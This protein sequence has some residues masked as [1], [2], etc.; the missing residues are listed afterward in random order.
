MF[1]YSESRST[2]FSSGHRNTC[3]ILWFKIH[4]HLNHS[5]HNRNIPPLQNC[6]TSYDGAMTAWYQSECRV[7]CQWLHDINQIVNFSVSDCMNTNLFVEF[8]VNVPGLWE[9]IPTKTNRPQVS[10]THKLL[11][12]HS[13]DFRTMTPLFFFIITHLRISKLVLS[14]KKIIQHNTQ[15]WENN[16]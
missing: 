8:E 16:Q 2:C 1:A 10:P 7:P 13:K 11:R 5:M 12:L 6:K 15:P 9:L 3:C 14:L 4:A